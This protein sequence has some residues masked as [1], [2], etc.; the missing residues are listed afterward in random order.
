[1]KFTYYGHSCFSVF[2]GGKTLL[3]DPFI[4]GNELAK[5]IDVDKI[6]TDYIFVSHGHFDH[7]TDVLRIAK[8]TGAKVLGNWELYNWFDKSGLK[9][10]HPI[11]PGGQ[12]AFDFGT[13]KCF[14]AQHSNSLPDG[15]YGGVACGYA[16]NT[17]NGSFYYSGDTGLTLDMQLIANWTSLD[18]AVFPVGDGL[19][20]GIGDAVKAARIVGVKN[21]VGVHF[22]TFTFITIDHLKAIEAFKEAGLRLYLLDI[23]ASIEL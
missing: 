21:V 4:T 11:N 20:M 16:F 7:T 1:M 2:A 14:I 15:S 23:G 12:F 22:D 3:F 5:D 10:L 18:F 17:P 9:N 19:T 8:R 6:Q 13:V